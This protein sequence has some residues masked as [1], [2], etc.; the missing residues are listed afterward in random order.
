M[1]LIK[2]LI[3]FLFIFI[4][5][6]NK[7]QTVNSGMSW[8]SNNPVT[9]ATSPNYNTA[10]CS[11]INYTI[12][13]SASFNKV[14]NGP[15]YSNNCML[16]PS[17]INIT[18]SF[19]D[20][21]ITF[22]QPVSNLK[23]RFVDLDENVSGLSQPEESI[24]QINPTPASISPLGFVNPFFLVGGVVTPFDNNPGN[25]NNDVSGWV[26]WTGSLSSVSFRYNRPGSAYALIIDSIYFDCPINCS[27]IADAGQ[28]V[29]LCN[30]NNTTLNA[31]NANAT[32]YLWSTGSTTSSI[33]VNTPGLYWVEVGDNSCSDIDT[34][35][36]TNLNS[37]SVQLGNDTTLCSTLSL[38]IHPNVQSGTVLWSNNS[39]SPTLTVNQTGS[40]WV[41]VTNS[42]GTDQ[43]TINVT[44]ESPP[45]LDLGNDTTICLNEVLVLNPVL[46][47]V[48][49][50]WQ[51]NSNQQSFTVSQQGN[52]WLTVTNGICTVSDTIFVSYLSPPTIELGNDTSACSNLITELNP[53]FGGGIGTIIWNNNLTDSTLI[54]NNSGI[55]WVEVENICGIERDS[56]V[57]TIENQPILNLGNDTTICTNSIY[58]LNPI[59]PN[60]SYI[61][62]DNS[63]NSNFT[64]TQ[65]GTYWVSV[66]TL[67]CFVSDTI[68]ITYLSPPTIE[69]GNDTSA[70]SNLITELNPVF[71][72]GI[73]TIIWNNNTTDSSLIVNNSG[74]YWVE[75][76]NIC[77]IERDSIVV[78]IENQ[79]TVN[80][81]NDTTICVNSTLLLNPAVSNAS[82]SWQNNSTQS[83]FLVNQAGIYWVDVATQNCL[84]RDSIIIAIQDIPT[85]NLGNDTII[86][87]G[88]NL[89][90]DASYPGAT[91]TWQNNSNA[92][93]LAINQ[94]GLYW[95]IVS[96]NCGFD[97]DSLNLEIQNPPQINFTNDTTICIGETYTLNAIT[98]NGTYLWSN[99]STNSSIEVNQAGIYT[100]IVSVG[101]CQIQNEFLI[102]AKLCESEFEMP[103]V[104]TPN[105]DGTNDLFS[106]VSY[107]KIKSANIIIVNRWGNVIYNSS[108]LISGW[109]GTSNGKECVEGV[110]FWKVE[111]EDFY[112][113]NFTEQG[114]IHLF[115]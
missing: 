81:G 109:D 14:S 100:V 74:I 69:L 31:F 97:S 59:I 106:P 42:C 27:I 26:N 48:N 91:Y 60:G 6:N 65:P 88:L 43:D 104:F 66:S 90:L 7:S 11:T 86:C 28:D 39:T 103:T 99:N 38:L 36:V 21:S 30:S 63:I 83:N 73:G 45:I 78:T 10:N 112:L 50:T 35:L 41:Q 95:V 15:P 68:Q 16:L 76:E 110:Y 56:I 2:S 40:Y 101:V 57:V 113:N 92:P 37:P 67:A 22:N 80:L 52:Y 23:I 20:V 34:V 96:N 29:V 71:G 46:S 49:Y 79:P 72:G 111:Y 61:W 5:G 25:N 82:F 32:S 108:N 12:N 114:F 102:N 8:L 3:L 53:V 55:Y 33:S 107:Q 70:C 18:N 87:N 19:I 62:Q 77:G 47:N 17:D 4:C 64:I 93:T 54:V 51:N 24:S 84:V 115:R 9:T 13:S 94:Q 98:P 105:G 75:V 44:F 58:V 1:Y 85:V 89:I